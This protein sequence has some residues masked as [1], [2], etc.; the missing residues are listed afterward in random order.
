MKSALPI[1]Q[2]MTELYENIDEPEKIDVN[3]IILTLSDSLSFIGSANVEMVKIRKNQLRKD[4]PK[5]MYGLCNESE[6]FSPNF[7]FGDDLKNKVKEV[8]ELNKIKSKFSTENFRGKRGM[9]RGRGR[10]NFRGSSRGNRRYTPYNKNYA[11]KESKNGATS[12]SGSSKA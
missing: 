8:S 10:F 7:L 6:E 4:L 12:K 1:A 5:N 2:V 9:A 11:S 3:K